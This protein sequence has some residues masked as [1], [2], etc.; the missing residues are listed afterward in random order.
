MTHPYSRPSVSARGVTVQMGFD[1]FNGT[2]GPLAFIAI[3]AQ[4]VLGNAARQQSLGLGVEQSDN[5]LIEGCLELGGVAV[6]CV[7]VHDRIVHYNRQAVDKAFL[8]FGL[9]DA[10]AVLFTRPLLQI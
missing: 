8:G 5:Q 10:W 9:E 3:V 1:G 7:R 6:Q 2:T 4:R